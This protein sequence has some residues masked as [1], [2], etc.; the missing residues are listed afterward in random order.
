MFSVTVQPNVRPVLT[1]ANGLFWRQ[2]R[3]GLYYQ[4][5][6]QYDAWVLTG[7]DTLAAVA[8]R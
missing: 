3:S 7:G 5:W 2:L 6:Q 4:R 8:R 1:A